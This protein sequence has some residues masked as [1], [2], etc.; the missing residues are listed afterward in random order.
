MELWLNM[1]LGSI[2]HGY[3]AWLSS[4][5]VILVTI[6]LFGMMLGQDWWSKL[7]SIW[8]KWCLLGPLTLAFKA[9]KFLLFSLGKFIFP[10]SGG[11]KNGNKKNG[12]GSPL[13]VNIYFG[14]RRE[15]PNR[16]GRGRSR[17]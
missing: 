13:N 4:T 11:K 7:G 5:L 1:V 6:C 2:T 8:V 9:G 17:N 3:G 14:G 16:S 15:D 12:K 10:K